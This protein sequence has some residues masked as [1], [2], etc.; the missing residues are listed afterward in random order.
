LPDIVD[1]IS[2]S[3]MMS[4]IRAKNTDPEIR[5]R[6]GLHAMG[7]RYRLHAPEV[8]GKPDVVLPRHRSAVFVNGCFWHG[9]DCPLYRLP[10]TRSDFWRAK[11][12]RN[13]ARDAVVRQQL[14]ETG[15]RSLTVWECAIRGAGRLGLD[16]TLAL[17][18]TWIRSGDA[19]GEIRAP[20]GRAV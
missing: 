5:I 15:W 13:R 14:Q 2:R 18:D 16:E 3:R 10:G 8:P 4:G 9:H 17:M 6:K 19:S 20:K 12:E 7:Y 11:I 1:S